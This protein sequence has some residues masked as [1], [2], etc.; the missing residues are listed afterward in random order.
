MTTGT[1]LENPDT[2]TANRLVRKVALQ[3]SGKE[4]FFTNGADPIGYMYVGKKWI[5]ISVSH[6]KKKNSFQVALD[7]HESHKNNNTSK[8]KPRKISAEFL[9]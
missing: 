1:D 6:H 2:H 4:Y 3:S 7:Q 9:G 5:L 8:R